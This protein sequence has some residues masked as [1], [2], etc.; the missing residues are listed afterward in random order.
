[1]QKVGGHRGGYDPFTFD[2]TG[3]VKPGD[4]NELVVR[5]WDPTDTES[6]PRGKQVSE[7][8]GIWYTAVTGIWQTV[9]LE[10]VPARRVERLVPVP[11]LD[12]DTLK[13][14][15]EV[16]GDGGDDSVTAVALDGDR[17]VARA[18]GKAGGTLSLS[19]PDAKRW[20]PDS[21]HLYGLRV[22][23]G[24]GDR[25]EST[26]GMRQ[27]ALAKDDK[28]VTR[29][30][31]NGEALFHYGPLDQGWWPDGL[32]TAPT[33][34]AMIHDL[35]VTKDLGFNTVRKHVKVEPATW[36][37]ACDR[38]GLL[39]WQDMPTGFR[40]P[41]TEERIQPEDAE[42]WT[43]PA[44]SVAQWERELE[45]MMR[46]THPFPSV[47]IYVPHNEG[48]G[49][50]D[51]NRIAEKIKALDPTRL[52]NEVSGWTDRG[53]G[54][55]IDA[56]LYP[57]PGMEPPEQNPGRAVVLGE[58]G[59][60][61][62]PLEKNLW[63]REKRNWGY[64]TYQS[65]DELLANY[66]RVLE[67]L[68]PLVYRGLSAAIYTQTTDVE[69][70]VNG[71]MT[72]DR[73]EVKLPAAAVRPLHEALYRTD[74]NQSVT[75]LAPDSEVEG[76]SWRFTET[77][78]E[79]GNAWTK[80]GFDD[81]AWT[82]AL[83]PIASGL[84]ESEIDPR[85]GWGES[86]NRYWL[87]KTF[88][89][90]AVPDGG[91][92]LKLYAGAKLRVF[93]NGRD[94]LEAERQPQH[95][96][97]HTILKDAAGALR[98]GENVLAV[99]A[100]RGAGPAAGFDAG[101]Y[102]FPHLPVPEKAGANADARPNI[103]FIFIDDMGYGDLSV[104]GNTHVRTPNM[105]RLAAEGMT[106]TQFHVASPICSPSRVAIT[107][108]QYPSRSR[109]NSYLNNRARNHER[110]MADFLDPARPAIARA[111]QGAG[112]A[113]AHFGKWHMG[114]GRDVGEAP[115]PQAY[116]FD[117]AIVSFEGLG[118]RVLPPGGLSAASE[119]LGR[120]EIRHVAKHEQTPIYVDRSIDFLKRRR[121]EGR[122]FYLH[123]WLNDV[124]D[125]HNPSPEQL[126]KW[127][128]ASDNPNEVRFF[129]VLDAMDRDL[130]RLLDFLD[131][132]GL[133]DNTVV[134]LTS[135]NG[136][137]AWPRYYEDGH[138]PAGST[139]GDRGR[140]WS[141]YQ[142][143]IHMPTFVRW[144][145]HIPAGAE[146]AS[147][148]GAV[149]LFP[150]FCALAGVEAPAA[151]RAGFDGEDLSAVLLENRVRDRARPLF[152]EYGRDATYLRPGLESDQSPS[153]AMRDGDWKVLVNADGTALELYDLAEDPREASNLNGRSAATS[154]RAV[155]MARRLLAWW[156]ELP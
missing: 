80:P 41:T 51:T 151:A 120:G 88:T 112:Y 33:E 26:F 28:G 6:H 105:D 11:D 91:I 135:D 58:F 134:F 103:L 141:L 138:P 83:L 25:V 140:K 74:P 126:A 109:V 27:I 139:F 99:L 149:D 31:L 76:Q 131:T 114:G 75:P 119:K 61:G 117:E 111:F 132:S 121:H 59:G 32:Y 137:T 29:L 113:T 1:G 87:R 96:Y 77:E 84:P 100:E 8:K 150:T 12:T 147:V 136:P 42:D 154:E 115:L 108:G 148:S 48:W 153:L 142:G 44:E 146:N 85:T 45:A 63:W 50:F 94:V 122:P 55:L 5:V 47:V 124:H 20:S 92:A 78:P 104:T 57:G 95:H 128:G 53:G 40:H 143:G 116:G 7:P 62:L 107:T 79:D 118:D 21:P 37:A 101:L 129:A 60:L 89:L 72:Y 17:E 30:F 73:A 4:A 97:R 52:V 86:A 49:Q 46:L 36:Y 93:L 82:S 9:W 106:L 39:V 68:R 102:A 127:E 22:E 81:S 123:L 19:L 35:R 64:R 65:H 13:L 16:A 71:L 18:T 145:G 125:G 90:D 10:A 66:R 23:L 152:W 67:D 144:P 56:H 155:Q 3:A 110:H 130:G 54:D 43:R 133:A 98:A 69:G 156:R 38:L 70:E 34:E 14:A 24:S 15:V 2:I